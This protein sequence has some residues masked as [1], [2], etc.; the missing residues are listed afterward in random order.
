MTRAA[1]AGPSLGGGFYGE[2]PVCKDFREIF[3]AR[4]KPV[5]VGTGG[6]EARMG[7]AQG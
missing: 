4:Q 6:S 7:R 2:P 1:S 5:A 3:N